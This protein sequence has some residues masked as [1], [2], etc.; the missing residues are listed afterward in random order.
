MTQHFHESWDLNSGLHACKASS[1]T[2]DPSLSSPEVYILPRYFKSFLY[3][4]DRLV[5]GESRDDHLKLCEIEAQR[6]HCRAEPPP[7]LSVI[8]YLVVLS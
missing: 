4:T 7:E 5:D 6:Q 8:Y 3:Q 2:H 1:L